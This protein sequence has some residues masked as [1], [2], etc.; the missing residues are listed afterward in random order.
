MDEA[1]KM[2][3]RRAAERKAKAEARRRLAPLSRELS[4]G[5]GAPTARMVG[6][7]AH[8]PTP[9]SSPRCC[10]NPRKRGKGW[11]RETVGE[12][13]ARMKQAE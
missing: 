9:C 13:K 3:K 1:L 11:R 10:G 4:W 2:S 12:I 5:V 6:K 8:T 7:F